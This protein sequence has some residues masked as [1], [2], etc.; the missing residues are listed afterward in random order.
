M[1]TTPS[2]KFIALITPLVKLNLISQ[3]VDSGQADTMIL[4]VS[5]FFPSGTTE[6]LLWYLALL[7]TEFGSVLPMINF[8]SW[9]IFFL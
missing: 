5:T 8:R 2:N 3:V 1:I 6:A 7:S 4:S 9:I